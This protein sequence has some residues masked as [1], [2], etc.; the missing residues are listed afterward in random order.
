VSDYPIKLHAKSHRD[1]VPRA[2]ID[3]VLASVRVPHGAHVA[4]VV[5]I[6]LPRRVGSFVHCGLYGPAM[7]DPPVRESEV[8]YA[9]RPGRGWVSRLVRRPLRRTRLLTVVAVEQEGQWVLATV[10]GGPEAPR[11]LEDPNLTGN[12][13]IEASAGFWADHALSDG[14]P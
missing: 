4:Y 5:T 9:T 7:G 2:V 10:Y 6:E 11:E 14:G 13:A 12:A 1:H 8:H 3:H